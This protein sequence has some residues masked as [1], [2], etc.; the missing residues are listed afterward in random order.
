MTKWAVLMNWAREA[1]KKVLMV[2]TAENPKYMHLLG[3]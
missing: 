2:D 3:S 1:H